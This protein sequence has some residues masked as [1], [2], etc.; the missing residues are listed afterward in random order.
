MI[1]EIDAFLL[2][3]HLR[4]F[5]VISTSPLYQRTNAA[6][7]QNPVMI[8]GT[9]LISSY[10]Y[11]NSVPVTVTN[12]ENAAIIPFNYTFQNGVITAIVNACSSQYNSAIE[13][14]PLAINPKALSSP[15]DM[16]SQLPVSYWYRL[17][18][19][20]FSS[21][22]PLSNF[23]TLG[24]NDYVGAFLINYTIIGW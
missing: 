22:S 4:S 1:D 23:E 21:C 8:S 5:D 24:G 12:K 14:Y 7:I 6:A 13:F 17:N 9:C 16:L 3:Q 18:N 20:T 15:D 10:C 2:D 11:A 19:G